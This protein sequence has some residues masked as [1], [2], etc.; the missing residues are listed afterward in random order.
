V[1]PVLLAIRR[2]ATSRAIRTPARPTRS[3]CIR[4][5]S[6]ETTTKRESFQEERRSDYTA[7]N[8]Q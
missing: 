1:M 3:Q 4:P 7:H 6:P 5:T 2:S 8:R